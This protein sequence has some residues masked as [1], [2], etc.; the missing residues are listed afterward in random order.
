MPGPA[1][2]LGPR[3]DPPVAL[4]MPLAG[5]REVRSTV[6]NWLAGLGYYNAVRGGG[7]GPF[8]PPPETSR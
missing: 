5:G 1:G 6:R 8:S 4:P 3:M 2:E 7:G